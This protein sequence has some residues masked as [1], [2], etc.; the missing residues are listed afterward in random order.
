Y[1]TSVLR[2]QIYWFFSIISNF[3]IKKN[4]ENRKTIQN[5]ILKETKYTPIPPENVFLLKKS[6]TLTQQP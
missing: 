3:L 1:N 5:Q 4:R 2:V 6:F